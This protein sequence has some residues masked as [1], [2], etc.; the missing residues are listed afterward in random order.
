MATQVKN[1]AS[2]PALADLRNRVIGYF[3]TQPDNQPSDQAGLFSD[4]SPDLGKLVPKELAEET[5][6]RMEAQ[7]L[8][9][10]DKK[11]ERVTAAREQVALDLVEGLK[12][13]GL[14]AGIK[15]NEKGGMG[16]HYRGPKPE[17]DWPEGQKPRHERLRI[18]QITVDK[19]I[20]QREDGL[21]ERVVANYAANH[22]S[23][24]RLRVFHEKKE[25]KSYYR[26]SRG[27]HRIAAKKLAGEDMVDCEVFEGD[28][29]AAKLDA[30]GDN[31]THGKPRTEK[32]I[33]KAIGTLL[34]IKGWKNAS[35]NM[36]AARVQCSWATA[37]KYRKAWEREN[38][39]GGSDKRKGSDGKE[40]PA[41]QSAKTVDP[42]KAN[43]DSAP[44]TA[45]TPEADPVKDIVPQEYGRDKLD[46]PITD[47]AVAKAFRDNRLVKALNGIEENLRFIEE[48]QSDGYAFSSLNAKQRTECANEI[49]HWL[50]TLRASAPHAACP[51]K[52]GK[53]FAAAARRGWMTQAEWQ[54]WNKKDSAAKDAASNG[55]AEPAKPAATSQGEK[56][57]EAPAN[58]PAA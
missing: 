50:D 11:D 18:D 9:L 48:M 4:I 33:R 5:L 23:L 55:K 24:P 15:L 56:S 45:G 30:V 19:S 6:K 36:I 16:I 46:K 34:S 31:A 27:F 8:Q 22:K 49:R 29:D 43:P 54:E 37:D 12:G 57:P 21:D 28:R 39:S 40:R 42:A 53:E 58:A 52:P 44:P 20:Q 25:G 14:I 47:E 41:A 26:L 1:P 38:Q 2:N 17:N 10:P 7:K 32:D 3:A 35:T 13:E 51:E